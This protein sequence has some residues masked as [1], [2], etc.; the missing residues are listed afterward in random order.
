MHMRIVIVS[1]S[2]IHSVNNGS[3]ADFYALREEEHRFFNYGQE[4]KKGETD[5]VW[6]E[7]DTGEMPTKKQHPYRLLIVA[8]R[9]SK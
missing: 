6:M 1:L 7:G 4:G 9:S 8:G 2:F 5:L 3:R